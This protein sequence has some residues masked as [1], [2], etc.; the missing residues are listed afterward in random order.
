MD[1]NRFSNRKYKKVLKH[2]K[3]M[4]K[5]KFNLK[6]IA[7]DVDKSCF[8][9]C[10]K[11]HFYLI[12]ESRIKLKYFVKSIQTFFKFHKDTIKTNCRIYLFFDQ[13]R[14]KC[15]TF[16]LLNVVLSLLTQNLIGKYLLVKIRQEVPGSQESKNTLTYILQNNK[17][18]FIN[19]GFSI[20]Y[21]LSLQKDYLLIC[22]IALRKKVLRMRALLFWKMEVKKKDVRKTMKILKI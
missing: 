9:C 20:M 16:L 1:E 2:Y 18:A 4:K 3:V 10:K 14:M 8:T 7:N 21:L 15:S 22:A 11:L 19:D 13:L 5:Y 17:L 12:L 6:F